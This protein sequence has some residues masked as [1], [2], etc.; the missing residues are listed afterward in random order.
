MSH[1][2]LPSSSSHRRQP[3]RHV[4][5]RSG[6]FTL[7]E[8][9]VVI[10]IIALLISILLPALN[11]ARE[12]AKRT[13]CASN[14]KQLGLV[15]FM[16]ANENKGKLPQHYGNSYWLF[17][18]PI[19]TRNE[20]IRYGSVRDVFYCPSNATE[21]NHDG[22][23]NFPTAVE[24][25]AA[26]S[27]TGYQFLFR[28]PGHGP[29]PSDNMMPPFFYSRKYLQKL[30]EKQTLNIAAQLTERVPADLELATDMVNSRGAPGSATESFT[31]VPGGWVGGALGH[32][33]AHMKGNMKAAGGNILFLDGHV[34]WRDFSEMRV[35]QQHSGNNYYF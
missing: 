22:L 34:S 13:Q 24:A 26:H 15:L 16:Y 2:A 27:A 21:Q 7:V 20:M 11:R 9:L 1:T 29:P 10:G 33:T 12:Q 31:F 5:R 28:R 30:T 6:A 18:I 25:T 19:P 32:H 14:L 23:W 17:D 35:Q 8:L 3:V 4:R